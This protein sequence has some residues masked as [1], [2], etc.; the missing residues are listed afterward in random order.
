MVFCLLGANPPSVMESVVEMFWVVKWEVTTIPGSLF[1]QGFYVW[2]I[3]GKKEPGHLR[4]KPGQNEQIKQGVFYI[5]SW[6][7][8][9][10]GCLGWWIVGRDKPVKKLTTFK[11]CVKIANVQIK[12]NENERANSCKPY[13]AYVYVRNQ[14]PQI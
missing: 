14:D 1:K 3:L 5:K 12:G 6:P 8:S 9:R 7:L 11:H 2:W 4:E 13:G 10:A